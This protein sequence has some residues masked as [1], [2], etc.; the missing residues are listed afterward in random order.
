MRRFLV[1]I[2]L[3]SVASCTK[4]PR[5]HLADLNN[6][7]VAPSEITLFIDEFSVG[8]TEPSHNSI[9]PHGKTESMR[10]EWFIKGD[11]LTIEGHRIC[12]RNDL[13]NTRLFVSITSEASSRET[14]LTEGSYGDVFHRFLGSGPASLYK[15]INFG[16]GTFGL[17]HSYG[18]T[19]YAKE[20]FCQTIE[21][22]PN[23]KFFFGVDPKGLPIIYTSAPLTEVDRL[24]EGWREYEIEKL[25]QN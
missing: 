24:V 11:C 14:V 10:A 6:S 16:K 15:V 9:P 5:F 1:S 8:S 7:S 21:V 13:I 18:F 25:C 3:L 22:N 20:R 17:A 12:Y 2:I 4:K 23:S 19:V